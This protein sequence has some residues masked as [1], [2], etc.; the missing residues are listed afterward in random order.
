MQCEPKLAFK[1][2]T[3]AN[4][5]RGDGQG[6][7]RPKQDFSI[8]PSA[9]RSKSQTGMVCESPCGL[10]GWTKFVP[11]SKLGIWAGG[12][13]SIWAFSGQYFLPCLHSAALFSRCNCTG[14]ILRPWPFRRLS[15][16]GRRVHRLPPSPLPT[17]GGGLMRAGAHGNDNSCLHSASGSNATWKV[18]SLHR[19]NVAWAAASLN[20]KAT[21]IRRSLGPTARQYAAKAVT[22]PRLSGPCRGAVDLQSAAVA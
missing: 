22:L 11:R 2:R 16:V 5:H 21:P 9:T 20:R 4:I 12:R 18:A 3:A 8:Y 7:R 17:G 19:T 1:G 6:Y 13:V 14:N 15:R 10:A